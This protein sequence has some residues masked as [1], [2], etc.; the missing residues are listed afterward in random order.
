[1]ARVRFTADDPYG[2][3]SEGENAEDLGWESDHPSAPPIRLF[4]LANDEVIALT[5]PFE[6]GLVE[7]TEGEW[8][9]S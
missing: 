4:R 8:L 2:G 5:D 9:A 3:W 7:Y 6:R 1:M